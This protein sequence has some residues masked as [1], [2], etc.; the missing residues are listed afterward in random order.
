MV[1]VQ[2]VPT[3]AIQMGWKG[4]CVAESALARYKSEVIRKTYPK[5]NFV[6]FRN[7]R[8]LMS[9]R[10][11]EQTLQEAKRTDLILFLNQNQGHYLGTNW[12]HMIGQVRLILQPVLNRF[13]FLDL[14]LFLRQCWITLA[15]NFG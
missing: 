14:T 4:T 10:S 3:V 13:F 12:R 5:R 2:D 7:R 9:S 11:A 6:L 1:L 15:G 8:S